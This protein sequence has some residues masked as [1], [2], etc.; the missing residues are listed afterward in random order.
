MSAKEK[1]SWYLRAFLQSPARL[2]IMAFA[3]LI[4]TG[5]LLLILPAASNGQHIGFINA[6]FTAT[7]AAC[8]TGLAVVDTGS[9]FTLF[10]QLVVLALIQVGGLGIMTIST[11]LLLMAGRRP[12]LTGR[13][14]VRD[15]FTHSGEKSVSSILKDVIIFTAV[16]EG[17]GAAAL[18]LRFLPGNEPGAALY[19]SIFHS[20]SA[21]CNA[22]FSLFSD[23]FIRFREDWILNLTVCFLII[24]GGIGFLVIA[25]LRE[26]FPY[27]RKRWDRLSLHSRIVLSTTTL[28]LVCGSL[29]VLLMEWHNALAPLNPLGRLLSS[30]FQSVSART[31]GFNTL[32][33]ET[34]ANETLFLIILLMFIGACPGS[35]GGGIKTTTFAALALLGLSRLRGRKQTQ[36][37]HRTIPE[38]SIGKAVSVL[39]ISMLVVTAGTMALLLTEL[40]DTPHPLSRGQFLDLLF[41]VVSA[42]GTV[43]LSTGVTPGLSALGRL[44]IT[45]VMFIGRL[46][47][48]VIAVAISSQRISRFYYAEE[49]IIIG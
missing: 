49:N 36:I 26:N 32:Q 47:P 38:E 3:V 42:F 40:G 11:L 48:L 27:N 7:S 2:S 22:G 15:T 18:F 29:S 25:E 34:L 13:L 16:I 41:E 5:T 44:I 24:C 12:G 33:F 19:L 9:R 20:I 1:M 31:A 23:S 6:F 30:F 8:V 21:F 37:F 35:C 46:G 43:G 39:L 45:A 10:G 4:L 28:L 14:V 17:L